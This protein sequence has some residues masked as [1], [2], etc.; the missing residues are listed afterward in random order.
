MINL[1]AETQHK[2]TVVDS[3]LAYMFVAYVTRASIDQ[4]KGDLKPL[5]VSQTRVPDGTG[6]TGAYKHIREEYDGMYILWD[7]FE[8]YF[9]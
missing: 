1:P 3:Y 5:A 9:G 7:D 8:Q 6:N 4:L 2:V